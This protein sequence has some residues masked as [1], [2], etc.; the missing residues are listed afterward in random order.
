MPF[1]ASA[2]P[3]VAQSAPSTGI[4]VLTLIT[5]ST[6]GFATVVTMLGPLLVDLSRELDVSLG[7]AG[8]L[9][10]AMAVPW[11]LTAPFAGVLSDRLGGGR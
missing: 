8:L 2:R 7:E 4:V 6:F 1:D 11:A 3:A 10:A 5:V 9:A